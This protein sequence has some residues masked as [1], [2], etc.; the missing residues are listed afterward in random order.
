VEG[1]EEEVFFLAAFPEGFGII[2]WT[3]AE[4]NIDI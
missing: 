1:V 4:I 2:E 3:I